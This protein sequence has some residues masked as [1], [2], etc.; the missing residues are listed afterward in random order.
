MTTTNVIRALMK[1]PQPMATSSPF[2][3]VPRTVLI[4]AKSTLPSATPMITPTARASAFDLVRNSRKPPMSARRSVLDDLGEGLR[5]GDP[6]GDLGLARHAPDD[7]GPGGHDFLEC[8][9]EVGRVALG[10]LGRGV[11]AR[12]LEEVRV[13]G[14]DA[15]DA[16]QVRVVHPL[17]DQLA[18]DA[19][20]GLEG[21]PARL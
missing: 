7:V 14:A 9:R 19:G 18:A 15:V 21:V 3:F 5:L 13:F 12:R 11:H 8:R 2:A 6:A 1:R 20:R 4:D 10:Q 17:E 16:H